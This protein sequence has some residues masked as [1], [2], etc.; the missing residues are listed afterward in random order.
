MKSDVW[1]DSGDGENTVHPVNHAKVQ[2]SKA[3]EYRGKG[4][5]SSNEFKMAAV[6][7]EPVAEEV[8]QFLPAP[9]PPPCP[10]SLPALSTAHLPFLLAS[11]L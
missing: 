6:Q 3:N 4:E 5:K 7:H 9:P 10:S 2:H 8:V 11:S 1:L